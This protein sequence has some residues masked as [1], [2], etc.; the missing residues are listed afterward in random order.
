MALI[1]YQKLV[2]LHGMIVFLIDQ[3]IKGQTYVLAIIEEFYRHDFLALPMIIR[4]P[5]SWKGGRA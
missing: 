3:I 2:A 5:S 4:A 1:G